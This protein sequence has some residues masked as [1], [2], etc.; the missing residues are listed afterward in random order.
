MSLGHFVDALGLYEFLKEQPFAYREEM[1]AFIYDEY[2]IV[3]NVLR[4][5]APLK[6]SPE[7]PE[8]RYMLQNYRLISAS[9]TCF[10]GEPGS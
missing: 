6:G 7:Y 4:S 1:Q 3:L 5:P 10:T 9:T 8:R 2:D